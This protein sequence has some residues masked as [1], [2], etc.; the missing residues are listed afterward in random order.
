MTVID[1]ATSNFPISGF[2]KTYVSRV[3]SV[4]PIELHK[5]YENGGQGRIRTSNVHRIGTRFTVWHNTT[6]VAAY[7][8]K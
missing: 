8:K 7:P 2:M 4:L 6:I 5:Y 1:A 3:L